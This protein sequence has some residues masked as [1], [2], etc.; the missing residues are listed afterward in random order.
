MSTVSAQ[1]TDLCQKSGSFQ[2]QQAHGV[3]DLYGVQSSLVSS[4]RRVCTIDNPGF[5][6]SGD[7]QRNSQSNGEL[8]LYP[9]IT[10]SGEKLPFVFAAW[11]GGG[12]LALQYGTANPTNVAGIV[13][14][15]VNPAG[16]EHIYY[17]NQTGI[18]N[19]ALAAYRKLDYSR[20]PLLTKSCST[21]QNYSRT[22]NFVVFDARL[23]S[24]FQC[25]KGLRTSRQKMGIQDAIV[26]QQKLGQT[27][28]WNQLPCKYGDDALDPLDTVAFSSNTRLAHYRCASMPH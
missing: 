14:L 27:N 21:L 4:G 16:I 24:L 8:Y 18:S 2:Q 9:V 19:D 12:S 13:F 23:R 28:C 25:S 3:V 1:R 15:A 26:D 6:W 17:L 5:A 7:V 20:Y 22:W 10:A 11:G